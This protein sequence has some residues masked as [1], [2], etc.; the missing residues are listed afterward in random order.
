VSFTL[1]K[2]PDLSLPTVLT[3]GELLIDFIS[4][5]SGVSLQDAPGFLKAPGGAPANVAVALNRLGVRSGFFGKVGED[6][7]GRFL[8]ETLRREGVDLSGLTF[9]KKAR[10]AL[11]F[12]S[13]R[14][15]GERDFHFYRDPS[16]DMLFH[17]RDLDTR[18]L[19]EAAG[20]H[21]GS[22]SLIAD[23]ARQATLTALEIVRQAHGFLS[24]DPNI[25]LPLWPSPEAAREGALLGWQ[26]A[27]IIKLSAEELSFLTQTAYP[28]PDSAALQ[29][30]ARS[31]WTDPLEILLVTQG[32][33]GCTVLT[34]TAA[35]YVPGFRVQ[36]V[37]TTGAGDGFMAGFLAK[38]ILEQEAETPG[39]SRPLETLQA[40]C[41]FANAAGA[42]TTLKKGAIPAFPDMN[43]VQTFLTAQN[44]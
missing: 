2:R 32:K 27:Q 14:E 11:A 3:L 18:S 1:K 8:A 19:Q 38:W 31:L 40:C 12:V 23:P 33:A 15:D 39:C 36:S 6:P 24:Y 43:Q 22:I 28:F 7:F 10:T 20:L 26:Q 4:L 34:P 25:R 44:V 30:T 37:D 41:Q 5:E 35:Q 16:A 42:L 29:R 17:P 21:Y 9:T 13:L